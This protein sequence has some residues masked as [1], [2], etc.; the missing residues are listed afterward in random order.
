[1]EIIND[2]V[3]DIMIK[4]T[5]E[6]AKNQKEG[7]GIQEEENFTD[8]VSEIIVNTNTETASRV[9]DEI[10][11][12]DT[13][14]NLSLEVI[15][16]I[17]EKDSEKLNE[18]SDNNKDQMDELTTDAVQK[19]ENTS[20][21][22]ELIAQVVS[23]I[24]NDLVNVMIEEVSKVSVNEKQTLSAKVLQ[25]I[26]ETEPDKIEIINEEVKEVMI[27][28]TVE[29]AKNQKEGTGVEEEENFT[30]IVS[31][32]IVN[33]NTETATKVI[34]EIND[35]DTETNLSLEVISGISEKD[36]GKL[37]ELSKNNKEQM[38]ELTTDAVQKAENTS[39]D[40]QLIANVVAVVN[41]D[42]VNKVVEEVSKSSTNE[43]QSLSAKV[44]K[45][46]VD[47]EPSKIENINEETK[48]TMIKQTLEA[49]KN[50]EEGQITDDENLSDVVADIVVK[51]DVDTASKIIEE[52][53]NTETDTSLSLKVMS[54]ISEKDSDKI[55]ELAENN[56]E[57]IE[58]L[59]E[60]AVQSAESTNEDSE[61]IAKV[62]AVA[63]E[64]LANKV[65]EEVSKTS[66]DDKQSLSAKV[67]KAIVE[68]EPSKI[69]T[70][71][72]EIK[73][74]VIDQA[75]EAAKDQQENI[76]QGINTEDEDLSDVVAD[77]VTKADTETASKVLETLDEASKESNSKLSLSVVENLTKKEN[78][79]E[80]IEILSVTSSSAD[81][82]INN[83]IENAVEEAED[84][85]DIDKVKN[86]VENSK[87]TISNKIIDSAKT[88]EENKKKISEVIVDIVKENPEKAVEI[89]QN[90]ENTQP[91]TETIKTKI[92]NDEAVTT[93]DFDDVFDTNISPN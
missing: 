61:L 14:T 25:K 67:L 40:S 32:I 41:D 81:K 23:V 85:E 69:E 8:I 88:N 34:E 20:E 54:G 1:M 11:E 65:V 18:L 24:N 42:L 71:D 82:N 53:N 58:N 52:V 48:T 29:S 19:A 36:S 17:S 68:T 27:K 75:I 90:N 70:L 79:E 33:T 7:I 76:D 38:D 46:I 3:K 86:I 62:V 66:T 47:T 50:Q 39:E 45:A 55:N 77:I 80:T 6:S 60:K 15:S 37:N 28:Q 83:I 59:A 89:I 44:L 93:E 4:Q 72:Q 26:V 91:V 22:S 13:E 2:E 10:N 73:D 84:K 78:F 21:D 16:G 63:S 64:E 35:I 51:T 87:G 12:I 43:K 56:L 31:E 30:D 92:E 74:T 49:A 9:I 57:S 5:V